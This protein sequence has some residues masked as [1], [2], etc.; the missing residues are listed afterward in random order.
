LFGLGASWVLDTLGLRAGVSQME[1]DAR[2]WYWFLFQ[3][4]FKKNY[5][6]HFS[7]TEMKKASQS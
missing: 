4:Q 1:V 5:V 6:N 2:Y 3:F 7:M